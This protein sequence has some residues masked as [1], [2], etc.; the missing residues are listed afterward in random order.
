MGEGGGG[1]GKLSLS[2]PVNWPST[3]FVWA[4]EAVHLWPSSG[5]LA[6]DPSGSRVGQHRLS[7]IHQVSALLPS[8]KFSLSN[9][10]VPAGRLRSPASDAGAPTLAGARPSR[11]VACSF[12][13]AALG[14]QSEDLARPL[15][16]PLCP[17]CGQGG[18]C[19][20]PEAQAQASLNRPVKSLLSG[21][22]RSC[23]TE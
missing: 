10:L 9:R 2:G 1:C 6:V 15:S 14:L 21:Y 22:F 19:G 3:V 20:S 16:P 13:K 12:Q 5:F 23:R 8:R 11:L 17:V 4:L 18:C 7:F